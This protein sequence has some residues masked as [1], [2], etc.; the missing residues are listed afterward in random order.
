MQYLAKHREQRES[1]KDFI[2][3]SRKILMAQ[4]AINDKTEETERLD[5]YIIM[6][7]D[8]LKEAKNTFNEDKSKFEKYMNDLQ[9]KAT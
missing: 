9:E 6:E 8:K 4:I 1:V 5:E 7:E 2:D 3:N